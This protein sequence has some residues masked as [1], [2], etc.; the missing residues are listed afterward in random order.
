LIYYRDAKLIVGCEWCHRIAELPDPQSPRVLPKGWHEKS[1][2]LM[3]AHACPQHSRKRAIPNEA[4]R[5][6]LP[7]VADRHDDDP[8]DVRGIID[9]PTRDEL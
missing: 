7:H 8:E 5:P 6:E 3:P 2:N 9:P 1:S 4:K